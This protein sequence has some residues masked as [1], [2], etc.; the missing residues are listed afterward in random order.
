MNLES[1]MIRLRPLAV[2]IF[3]FALTGFSVPP[4]SMAETSK[5]AALMPNVYMVTRDAPEHS[6]SSF[7]VTEEGVV[8]IDTGDGPTQAEALLKDIR[9][10]T[11]KPV[12]Y[13][14]NTHYHGENSFGNQVFKPLGTLITQKRTWKF[15]GGPDGEE[16]LQAWKEQGRGDAD[17]V[18][19]TLP[20]L[21]FDE[22]IDLLM[23]PFRLKVMY[24]G[25]GHTEGDIAIY[26]KEL[27]LLISGGLITHNCF[28]DM[29][30][31]Y[32]DEWMS[33][34]IEMENLDVET[35]IPGEGPVGGRP[36]MIQMKHFFIILK[37]EVMKNLEAGQ[38]LIE[39]QE[40]VYPILAGKYSHWKG[41]D[42]IKGIIKRAYLEFSLKKK[43]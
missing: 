37:R 35:L 22:R 31:S 17:R 3:S 39:T 8:V 12:R 43:I 9:A 13:I 32:I 33:A 11:D 20:S 1:F 18:S 19:I 4:P 36:A 23:K 10:V 38:S 34:L 26:V 24:F 16:Y 29:A 5:T 40:A 2:L 15:L 14:L 7:F 42:R 30:D 41:K 27:R 6:N 28:P 25:R 21:T